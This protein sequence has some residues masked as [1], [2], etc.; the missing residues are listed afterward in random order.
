MFCQIYGERRNRNFT[1]VDI[2]NEIVRVVPT[3]VG[4]ECGPLV[5]QPVG[6]MAGGMC[7][8]EVFEE[9]EGKSYQHVYKRGASKWR[10]AVSE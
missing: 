3:V 4:R 6:D 1:S 10:F 8:I 7:V 5:G 2:A 9:L